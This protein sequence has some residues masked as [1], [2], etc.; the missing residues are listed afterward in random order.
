MESFAVKANESVYER[1]FGFSNVTIK[2]SS[3]I[4]ISIL[5]EEEMSI[6]FIVYVFMLTISLCCYMG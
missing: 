1:A 6:L 5:S 3:S 2:G 4:L